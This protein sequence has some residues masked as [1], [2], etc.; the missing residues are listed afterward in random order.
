MK[1]C[2]LNGV[3]QTKIYRI[4]SRSS[5]IKHGGRHVLFWIE[6]KLPKVAIELLKIKRT[7][8]IEN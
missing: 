5:L 1:T 6:I 3:D 8:C 4:N 7:F 2:I